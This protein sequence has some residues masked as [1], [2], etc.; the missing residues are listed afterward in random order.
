M[1]R[2]SKIRI[3]RR[4]SRLHEF[5]KEILARVDWM[6]E[7]FFLFTQTGETLG[8]SIK[9]IGQALIA[10]VHGPFA[11]RFILQPLTAAF[12]ACRAGLRDARAG[13]PPFGWVV[14]TNSADRHDLLRE[15]WKEMATVF[16]AAV[17]VDLL[18]EEIVFHALYPTQSLI[19][20]TVLALLPYPLFRGPLNRIVR[21]WRDS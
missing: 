6:F 15:A 4:A 1:I 3:V 13:R 2:I 17:T 7:P 21:R 20:A 16:I 19:V 10:R 14:I 9:Q 18:Y 12:I 11:F 5:R 8:E